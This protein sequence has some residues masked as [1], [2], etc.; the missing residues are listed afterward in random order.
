MEIFK[1]DGYLSMSLYSKIKLLDT[2][3]LLDS[4]S[5]QLGDF[6]RCFYSGACVRTKR[7]TTKLID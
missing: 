2:G 7:Q 1:R 4:P 5:A 6:C 3:I